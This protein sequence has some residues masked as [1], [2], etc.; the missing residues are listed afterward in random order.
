MRSTVCFLRRTGVYSLLA[1]TVS[2]GGCGPSMPANQFASIQEANKKAEDNLKAI[3]KLERKNY[4]PLG[5][6]WIV[7]LDKAQVDEQVIKD[8]YTLDRITE[9]HIPGATITDG[10]LQELLTSKIGNFLNSVDF[11]G[12]GVTDAGVKPL[13]D[14]RWLQKAKISGTK[15]SDAFLADMKAQRKKN[16]QVP[17]PCK[18]V[19]VTK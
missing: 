11:S 8:L 17:G 10:Q 4:G 2:L 5:S 16:D 6:G 7:K 3:G 15:I 18:N 1:M 9:L 13:A 14:C 19:A 12:T